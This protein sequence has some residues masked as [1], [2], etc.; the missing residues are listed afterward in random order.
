MNQIEPMLPENK[1]VVKLAD[2]AVEK[3]IDKVWDKI[4]KSLVKEVGGEPISEE[5]MKKAE[6]EEKKKKKKKKK[7][8]V[9]GPFSFILVMYTLFWFLFGLLGGY[10]PGDVYI[11]TYVTS[12]VLP[13]I[14]I[15]YG[16]KG[17]KKDKSAIWAMIGLIIGS[18]ILIFC[19]LFTNNPLLISFS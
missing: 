10:R 9:Y 19:I 5:I 6:K 12:V 11:F 16:I 1:M 8:I 17:L 14:G 7:K 13:L 2:K 15:I 4:K 3:A 18:V